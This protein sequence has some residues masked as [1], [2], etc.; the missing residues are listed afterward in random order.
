MQVKTKICWKY[1]KD[2][3]GNEN[4]YYFLLYEINH[5]VISKHY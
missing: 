3:D 5:C 4:Y 1:N 2:Y